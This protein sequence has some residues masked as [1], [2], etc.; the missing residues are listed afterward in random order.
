MKFRPVSLAAA[1]LLGFGAAEP[2]SA[3][4]EEIT[5]TARQRAEKLRDVP[6]TV[7]VLDEQ[8]IARAR[9]DSLAEVAARAPGF[10]I[11]DPFGRLNPSPSVRGLVQAGIGDEPNVGLFLDG[12]Y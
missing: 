10:V 11:S 3:Q 5:V 7:T 6:A 4:I 9:I 1:T 2:A 8:T 12:T